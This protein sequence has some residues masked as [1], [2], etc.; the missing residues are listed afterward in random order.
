MLKP[1]FSRDAEKFLRKL[2]PKHGRQV[3]T[4]VAELL[5]DPLPFDSVA[6][7]SEPWF[8]RADVGEYRIIYE[9]D[10]EFLRIAFIDKRN[11]AQVYRKFKRRS[12]G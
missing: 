12:Q 9:V 7:K 10:G 8:R 3:A 1:D 11:D 5:K 2:P 4:K 6:L